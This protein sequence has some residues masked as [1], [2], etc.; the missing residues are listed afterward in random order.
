MIDLGP[1]I[2]IHTL[3]V[4]EI[5]KHILDAPKVFMHTLDAPEKTCRYYMLS[6]YSCI[7]LMLQ[8]DMQMVAIKGGKRMS[9][10]NI[11]I[12]V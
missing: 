6:R 1:Y 12:D 7:H 11:Y 8:M 10:M 3:D 9:C 5:L 4:L 2:F